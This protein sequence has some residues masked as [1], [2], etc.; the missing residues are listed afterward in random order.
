MRSLFGLTLAAAAAFV[1]AQAGAQTN[2]GPWSLNFDGGVAMPQNVNIK[3]GDSIEFATGFRVDAGV[4]Y[5]FLKPL[6]AEIDVGIIDNS[7]T[8]IG[9]LDVSSYG[10]SASLY[11]VPLV[12]QVIY[13][14]Q[15]KGVVRPFIG[16]GFGGIATVANFETP[17]GSINDTDYTFCYQ[18][19]AGVK[20]AAGDHLEFGVAYKFLGTL[21]HSW[22]EN[23]VTLKTDGILTH[24]I[25]AVV[26]WKF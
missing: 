2:S 23:G 21:D 7:V 5:R 14:P 10:G 6:V 1:T 13:E 17:L 15:L 8:R 12:A 25:M 11:Q 26:T 18:G 22:S 16:A 24:T 20:L 3:G 4:G 19:V 9:G